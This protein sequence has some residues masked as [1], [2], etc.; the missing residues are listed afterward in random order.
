MQVEVTTAII[1]ATLKVESRQVTT[2]EAAIKTSRTQV[3]TCN[4]AETLRI[5]TVATKT[6]PTLLNNR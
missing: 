2:M 1:K 5:Y 4:T 6:S 3:H